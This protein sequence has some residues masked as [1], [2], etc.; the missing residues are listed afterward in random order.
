MPRHA[1]G[2]LNVGI[3]AGF[4]VGDVGLRFGFLFVEVV[5]KVRCGKC[6]FFS[7]RCLVLGL[8][9]GGLPRLASVPNYDLVGG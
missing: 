7:V 2:D 6:A 3:G 9:K 1:A 5:I 4:C 8:N